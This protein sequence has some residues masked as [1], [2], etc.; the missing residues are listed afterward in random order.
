MNATS[1]NKP[2]AYAGLV[3]TL[4]GIGISGL[5]VCKHVFPEFCSSS[6]GCTIGGVDGCSELG[7]SRYSKIFGIPI[8]I[9]GF[10]FYATSFALFGLTLRETN[11]DKSAALASLLF[12]VAVFGAVFDVVLGYINFTKLVVPCRLCIY[13]YF[14]TAGFLICAIGIYV[15]S[16]KQNQNAKSL[17]V[18][19]EARIMMPA[20]GAGLAATAVLFVFLFGASK[21]SGKPGASGDLLPP[22][23][24]AD[25]LK[26]FRALSKVDISTA[27]LD[28]YEGD[29]NAY[30]VIQKFA[31]FMCPHCYHTSKELQK[32]Q[33]RWPGRIRIYYRHFPLDGAC[34][35]VVQRKDPNYGPMRCNGA[36]AALCGGEQKIFPA[37]YHGIFELQNEPEG[38]SIPNLQAVTEKSGGNWVKL[39]AC[40]NSPKTMAALLRDVK[41]AEAIK[42]NSTP[43]LIV[44]DRLLPPGTPDEKYFMSLMDALVFEKEG[45]KGY[46]SYG[47]SK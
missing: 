33:A 40:M 44:Q 32:A 37:L 23:Q 18:K 19:E 24:T 17:S 35:P 36:K 30:I 26:D 16:K 47:R 5:L 27:G 43:T 1:P 13:T 7:S 41:D 25:F 9:P 42:L 2:F 20:A 3:F 34:N 45:A 21:I 29:E 15:M 11:K 12:T 28:G 31:D 4:I 38:I 10:F 46:E 14:C 6:Y 39:N 22:D 8:A